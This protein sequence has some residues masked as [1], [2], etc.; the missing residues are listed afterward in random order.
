[1]MIEQ[2]DDITARDIMLRPPSSKCW[3]V[4]VVVMTTGI[5][6]IIL[7][8]WINWTIQHREPARRLQ[9]DSGWWSSEPVFF[10]V[11]FNCRWFM[12]VYA[13][14]Q[15]CFGCVIV[16]LL[17]ITW[18]ERTT[19]IDRVVAINRRASPSQRN[20]SSPAIR[21]EVG[22]RKHPNIPDKYGRR[23]SANGG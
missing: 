18:F 23:Y 17:R 4:E 19:I 6:V 11:H 21:C 12:D 9:H 16:K 2:V 20:G 13:Q 14:L 3:K 22:V 15:G 5:T 7:S 1:M 10:L 8:S